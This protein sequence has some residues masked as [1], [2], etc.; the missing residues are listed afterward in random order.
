MA[1]KK[2]GSKPKKLVNT[3]GP[4]WDSELGNIPGHSEFTATDE[5][6]KRLLRLNGIEPVGGEVEPAV[7]PEK[8]TEE[9]A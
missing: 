5:Q 4:R 1:N 7:E 8:A 9:A 6:A 2:K 3:G